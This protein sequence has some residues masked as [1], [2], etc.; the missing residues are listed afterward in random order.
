MESAMRDPN[1]SGAEL[2]T[3][4][5]KL[6]INLAHPDFFKPLLSWCGRGITWKEKALF[7]NWGWARYIYALT[8]CETSNNVLL[9][10]G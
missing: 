10:I 4:S 5:S 2:R 8:R 6:Y 7:K 3:P 1:F 9:S